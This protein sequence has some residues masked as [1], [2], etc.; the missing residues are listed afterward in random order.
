MQNSQQTLRSINLRWRPSR[1]EDVVGQESTVRILRHSVSRGETSHAYLFAGPR[2]TGKT[3]V[4]R[5][6]AKAINC[7]QSE[8]GE[9]CNSC[10]SCNRISRGTALDI[11]EIDGA[12]NRGIDKIRDLREEVSYTPAELDY[13]VYIIDEVHMLTNQAFNALLKTLE[14]PPDRVTF[15]FATTEPEKIPTTIISRCQVFEFKEIPRPSIF[16]RLKKVSKAEEIDITDEAL[17]L[18]A[19][20][21]RG[22]MRD[23]LVLLEQVLPYSSEKKIEKDSLVDLLGL[24]T[25]SSVNSFL[26]SLGNG[27]PRDLLQE[28]D[29]LAKRGRDLEIFLESV[30]EELRDRIK[31]GVDRAKLETN[32]E[33]S[34][35]LLDILEDLRGSSNKQV[36]LE[37]GSLALLS[38]IDEE[39]P[40]KGETDGN[41]DDK[42]LNGEPEREEVDD[43]QDLPQGRDSSPEPVMSGEASSSGPGP[44]DGFEGEDVRR[45]VEEASGL[46]GSD[47]W[48]ELVEQVENNRISIAAFLEESNPVIRN[49]DLILEFSR[50]FAFH[51]ESLEEN[52]NL[53]YLQEVVDKYFADVDKVRIIYSEEAGD[54]G[55][56]E[57][58]LLAKK[59]DLVKR[60]VGGTVIEEGRFN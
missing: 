15:I 24:P 48:K 13:K 7:E 30:L 47:S 14:E 3:S 42:E 2:G 32:V 45:K 51:K 5:I 31:G 59:A 26:D 57:K 22:S 55:K 18:I 34:R 16:E 1:F 9:P 6:M 19:V 58:D 39:A 46:K 27:N 28:I 25:D 10:D 12:S 49:R 33:L 43:G 52:K 60:N 53:S 54:S 23:G 41:P 8:D 29:R 4:A 44:N 50:E 38:G 56:T 11:V 21:A 40:P 36:T 35:G 37:I 17:E 20:R